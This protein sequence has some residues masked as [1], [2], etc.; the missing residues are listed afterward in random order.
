VPSLTEDL[1]VYRKMVKDKKES[2]ANKKDTSS[3][4]NANASSTAV[5]EEAIE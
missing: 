1:E 5:A 3:S 4:E 2:K